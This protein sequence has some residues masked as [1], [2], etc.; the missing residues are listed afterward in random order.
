MN[1][2]GNMEEVM[3]DGEEEISRVGS[4]TTIR[5]DGMKSVGNET[6]PLLQG[7]T[8]ALPIKPG[9]LPVPE[10]LGIEL[11]YSTMVEKVATASYRYCDI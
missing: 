3:E 6:Q 9:Q 2:F 4:T 11:T 7:V 10:Y 1:G 8:K 5:V